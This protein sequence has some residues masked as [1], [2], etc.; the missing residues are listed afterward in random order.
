MSKKDAKDARAK[1]YIITKNDPELL[2]ITAI[3][4]DE[5]AAKHYCDVHNTKPDY[6]DF[7]YEEHGLDAFDRNEE[8][9]HLYTCAM[10]LETG[11]IIGEEERIVIVNKDVDINERDLYVAAGPFSVARDYKPSD[12]AVFAKSYVSEEKAREVASDY[13]DLIISQSQG[14]E[15]EAARGLSG[16]I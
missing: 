5:D 15:I 8:Q 16:K 6:D 9:R 7:M 12:L 3:T 14:I 11:E 1:V 4:L 2:D 10:L 13:R